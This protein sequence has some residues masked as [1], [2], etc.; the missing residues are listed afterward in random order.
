MRIRL[1]CPMLG[2]ADKLIRMSLLLAL[3]AAWIGCSEGGSAIRPESG[4]APAPKLAGNSSRSTDHR[5]NGFDLS[6]LSIPREEIHRGGPP[7]DG[8]PAI[9]APKFV[10][11]AEASFLKPDDLVVSVSRAGETRAYP[12]RILV[13]HEIVNDAIGTNYFSVT[14]C[15]L[16]GT[17]M[18]FDRE[19]AGRKLDF[20]VSGLLYRSDVLMYDRQTESLWSQLRM[21]GVSGEF[22]R[23]KLKHLFSEHLT[24][25]AWRHK[26]PSGK[27]LSTDTGHRRNYA[28]L[29]Y[30]GY[31]KRQEIMFPVGDI[32][33]DLK[34]KDWVI[35]LIVDEVPYAA[36]MNSIKDH[37]MRVGSG[38]RTIT[39]RFDETSQA[40]EVREL[41]TGAPWPYVKAYWFAWQA[42]Y[43]TTRVLTPDDTGR[44]E[45]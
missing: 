11:I 45:K 24:F 34:N 43:P 22:N 44:Q 37:E 3:G 23:M 8:I 28:V 13:W 1:L 10:T 12:L 17:C 42:F 16:C 5:V 18:V 14:F 27:V 25:A 40:A 6:S 31:E 2:H 33:P 29:P 41:A 20:G 4:S 38:R 21:S 35:G 30:R 15:P 32:R 26:Y 36:P 39:V 19:Y 9:D 7:R